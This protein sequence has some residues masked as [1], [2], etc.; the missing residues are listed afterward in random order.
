MALMDTRPL[1][2]TL[3]PSE[4]KGVFV[5]VSAGLNLVLGSKKFESELTSD[6]LPSERR[7]TS[8]L[9]HSL[10]MSSAWCSDGILITENG[11]TFAVVPIYER[12]KIEDAHFA[13]L[14]LRLQK[15]I[16]E[17]IGATSLSLETAQS[18]SLEFFE[19][20]W[21]YSTDELEV[22]EEEEGSPGFFM[23]DKGQLAH[24]DWIIPEFIIFFRI[25]LSLDE[26]RGRW[27]LEKPKGF[28]EYRKE[29]FDLGLS[30]LMPSSYLTRLLRQYDDK[31]VSVW[32]EKWATSTWDPWM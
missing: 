4:V 30:G 7:V 8:G 12:A 16:F 25:K 17:Q 5:L 24:R 13:A 31:P 22:F 32:A 23:E 9:S 19:K 27:M 26:S 18:E 28:L 15:A 3:T 2:A 21:G 1:Q 29:F 14:L 11:K 20:E 6:L 10:K